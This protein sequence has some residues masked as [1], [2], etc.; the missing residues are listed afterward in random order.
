MVVGSNKSIRKTWHWFVVHFET[1]QVIITSLIVQNF[2]FEVYHM[3]YVL[4]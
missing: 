1:N 3:K 4:G 2:F